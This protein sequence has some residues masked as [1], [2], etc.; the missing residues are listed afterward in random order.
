MAAGPGTK[1]PREEGELEDGEICDDEPQE[2]VRR[3]QVCPSTAHFRPGLRTP[4]PGPAGE[5][6]PRSSFWERSH[7]ALGRLRYRGRG[8]GNRGAGRPHPGR[9]NPPELIQHSRRD[10]P[11]RRLLRASAGPPVGVDRVIGPRCGDGAVT[12]S[13]VSEEVQVEV[14]AWCLAVWD[15]VMLSPRVWGIPADRRSW[16]SAEA[17]SADDLELRWTPLRAWGLAVPVSVSVPVQRAAQAQVMADLVWFDATECCPLLG[18]RVQHTLGKCDVDVWGMCVQRTRRRTHEAASMRTLSYQE[19]QLQPKEKQGGRPMVRKPAYAVSKAENGVEESFEDLLL[20]YKQIQLELE[21]IRNEEKKALKPGED[22][23]QREEEEAGAATPTPTGTEGTQP[24]GAPEV[25]TED[26]P[27]SE[28]DEKKVFQ[29]FNLRPLR[30]KLLTPAE[31][32]ALKIKPGSENQEP[33]NQEPENQE[34]ENQEP[35]NQEPE[36]QEPE[37]QEPEKKQQERSPDEPPPPN[38]GEEDEDESESDLNLSLVTKDLPGTPAKV[39]GKD[40]DDELSELQLRLLALQ[41]ASRRWQQK[42]QQ[43]MKESKEKL[44]RTKTPPDRTSPA[45]ERLRVTTR[46]AS[47]GRGRAGVGLRGQEKGKPAGRVGMERGK[48]APK[49]HNTKKTIS[50]GPAAKQAFRKQQLRTWKLQ[51]QQEEQR[52]KYEEEE[53]RRKRE[54]EIRRIRDL[55]NQD[56]QYNRFMKLVGG[57]QHRTRSKSADAEH[58]KPL[59]KQGV[60]TSGNLYQ[61]DNYDEVAMDTDSETNSPAVSPAHD[62]FGAIGP[63]FLVPMM[64]FSSDPSPAIQDVSQ[65][66]G[67]PMGVHLA[68]P[69]PPPPFPPP[70]EPE[71]PPK[72]PF[73]D[74]E[75]EEEMLLREELLKSLVNKRAVRA[76]DTS[77][78]SGPPSPAPRP[79]ALS[80]TRTSA[81]TASLAGGSH[82]RSSKFSR[83]PQ[84]PRPPLVLPRHK[85]VVVRLNGS[86]DSDSEAEASSSTRSVFGGLESMIK[87]ARRTVEAAKPRTVPA[88]E[89]ENNPLRTPETLPEEK[90]M[91]YRLLMEELVSREMQRVVWSD[92]ALSVPVGSEL[93]TVSLQLINAEDKFTKHRAQLEKDQALLEHLRQ[94]ELRKKESL[95][96]AEAKVARL[97]EQLL[98]SER[99]VSAN[100][101]LLKKLQEQVHRVQH[102]VAVKQH[103]ALRLEKEMLMAQAGAAR[104]GYKRT[105]TNTTTTQLSPSKRRRVDGADAHY[106][107]L[108]AQKKRLQQLE[109]EYALKIQKLKEAQALRQ[110]QAPG[111]PYRVPQPSLHDLTQD[112]LTLASEDPDPEEEELQPA[113]A[114]NTRRRSFRESGSFTKPKLSHPETPTTPG[115]P[116]TSAKHS[117]SSAGA[118]PPELLLGLNV[119]DLRLRYQQSRSLPELLQH[120]LRSLGGPLGDTG[121]SA[122]V[123]FTPVRGAVI[124]VDFD[125]LAAPQARGELKPVPFGPYRSPLLV[126]RSYRFSPY[127][128]TKEKLSLSSVTYSNLIEPKKSFCRFD[129]TGTCNDDDCWWQHMRNCTLNGNQLFQ[130]VLSYSLPLIGCSE[131]SSTSEI[132]RAT[133]KYI[134][135]LFGANKDRMGTDQKAVL[136]VS[137]VNESLRHVP[138]YTT[139]KEKRKW[140]PEPQRV[141]PEP[142]E[143]E[144]ES[145]VTVPPAAPSDGRFPLCW[146]VSDVCV[147]QDDKRYFDSETDDISNLEYSVL[148]SPRDVQ[149]WIKLA[150]KYLNQK[151][152]SGGECLDA[153]LNTLSRALEDNREDVEVWCHYLSLFSRRGSRDEVQEMCE[154]AVEHAPHYHVWWT[155]LNIENTFEG[156]DAVCNSML[157]FLL[158]PLEGDKTE[159]RSFQLLETL[160]YRTQLSVFTGRVHNARTILQRAL[161]SEGKDSVPGG[162]TL[163]HRSLAWLCYI[164][165]CEFGALP[166]RLFDPANSNPS[167]IV[168]LEHFL[169]PWNSEHD[170]NTPPDHLVSLFQDALSRCVD[171]QVSPADRSLA[172]LPLHTNLVHLLRLLG[173]QRDAVGVCESVLS[174]CPYCCPLLEVLSEMHL[175]SG[176][177]DEAAGVWLRAH[178]LCPENAQIFYHLYKHL[179]TQRPLRWCLCNPVSVVLQGKLAEAEAEVL[180][181]EFVLSFCGAVDAD[182]TPVAVL[183]HLLGLP[184]QDLQKAPPSIR[185]ELQ[186]QLQTQLP[187]LSLVHALWWSVRGSMVEAV[188]A[189]EAALGSVSK[190]DVLQKLWLDYLLFAGSKVVGVQPGGRELRMFTDL[191]QRCLATVPSRVTLP[192]NSTT[193]WSSYTFHNQ[194][195]SLFLSC[196]PATLH[197]SVLER[198]RNSM[199]TN[200]ELALRLLQ[201]EWSEGNVEHVRLQTKM[202]SSSAPCCLPSWRIAVAVQTEQKG[203]AEV[204]RLYQQALQ[205]LPLCAALWKDWLLF[206]AAGGGKADSLRKLV[207][208]CQDVGVSL[209]EPLRLGPASSEAQVD[210]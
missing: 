187:Y 32:D 142:G 129:L 22:S 6:S 176:A 207:S 188:E 87:E 21:S 103:Q 110:A 115:T 78:N 151:D 172:C 97:K 193:Y 59:L 92:P 43:V 113:G 119:E 82:A 108:I 35:E 205:K 122:R 174:D 136:L 123:G 185:P 12:V 84:P 156:K 83:G 85:A 201:Q 132:S 140:R 197:A 7:G 157:Q 105:T 61:Y 31:R 56:E 137:K 198:L 143:S 39:K 57:K 210:S 184:A 182:L 33:E 160:L 183:R 114:T 20:K 79:A 94:Q 67:D 1:S 98:A 16:E 42:E 69:P 117:S 179:H 106:L 169:L 158:E 18:V 51:R 47:A 80:T 171:D 165:L 37:N 60:D 26:W 121:S 45:S 162:L 41:S 118:P 150:Y 107:E 195:I 58:R 77:S 102:R 88:S 147:T 15:D 141:Q 126:F 100:R 191:L 173:R 189:F 152:S 199:P 81:S 168:S 164:H 138:P 190:L 130:D 68:T 93:D 196:L 163:S 153:A 5:P 104:G 23:P 127:F 90:K 70:D 75:E 86:D 30:Q 38:D 89:K 2:A 206:E 9:Y 166:S 200:T 13:G 66:C 139:Y 155:Y 178:S 55:S 10:S 44:N 177:V 64:G 34:P 167:R 180:F 25:S 208:K 133:E 95:K 144:E 194:V 125:P 48:P 159:E 54:D 27:G 149:L 96:T 24:Q 71:R 192:Y 91:E 203:R 4:G 120:E 3:P 146:S 128:R 40:E 8:R 161:L 154:M 204:Q 36:N 111:S 50:P 145:S 72:P 101:V 202:L 19:V 170:L 76:E 109:S 29:A 112:K 148:E 28:R 11:N 134:K 17:A 52:Q 181:R 186:Q 135:K 49:G 209:S 46:S 53:E 73:A 124:Q 116:A 65:Y 63:P 99:V 74:E 175:G 131:D 14:Q 62:L